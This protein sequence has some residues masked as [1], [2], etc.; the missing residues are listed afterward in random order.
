M[1]SE[2]IHKVSFRHVELFPVLLQVQVS[3]LGRLC[4][5]PCIVQ[6]PDPGFVIIFECHPSWRL[7][8]KI[9]PTFS[10]TV[11]LAICTT[12]DVLQILQ[13]VLADEADTFHIGFFTFSGLPFF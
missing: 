8:Q 3:V 7:L 11:N 10:T 9:F 13:V 1:I 2:M 12:T 5:L 6:L 4:C